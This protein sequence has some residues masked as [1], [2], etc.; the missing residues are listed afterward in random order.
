MNTGL[1][2]KLTVQI[3]K[4]DTPIGGS[5]RRILLIGGI[6]ATGTATT[7]TILKDVATSSTIKAELGVSSPIYQTLKKIND[8][9]SKGLTVDVLPT[10]TGT[11]T[12]DATITIGQDALED[13]V[14]KVSIGGYSTQI[15]VTK[16]DTKVVVATALETA[17]T[18]AE[19]F[20]VARVGD[21]LTLT[22]ISSTSDFNGV[23][24]FITDDS[25]TK[26][27]STV[28]SGGASVALTSLPTF[29]ERYTS[30][31]LEF[32]L[33]NDL[34][35]KYLELN[36]N[37][38]NI[39]L[40]GVV[41]E[42]QNINVIGAKTYGATQNYKTLVSFV[43]LDELKFNLIPMVATG[44]I[45][46]IREL[47]L[48]D[49]APIVDYVISP[50]EGIGGMNKASLPYFNTPLGFGKP[51]GFCEQADYNALSDAGVSTF[52]FNGSSVLGEVITT[53]KTDKVGL[54]DVSWKFLNYVDTMS[55]I[56]EYFF[57]SLRA[58]FGQTRMTDGDLVKGIAITNI[59]SFKANLVKL[60]NDL[61]DKGN[62]HQVGLTRA[63]L[64]SFFAN[65]CIVTQDL[66]KGTYNF[67]A[68]TP[69]VTQVRAIN[70]V[71]IETLDISLS[72]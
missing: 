64:G 27:V 18:G 14:L 66:A 45:V 49:N 53:Y 59:G 40:D 48:T 44:E 10:T 72:I 3:G 38:E 63:G 70:G 36:F 57:N 8:I 42:T 37:N 28:F 29:E 67:I 9:S 21:V 51:L 56:R 5:T 65:N 7:D 39:I 15:N 1:N 22:T 41:F 35:R 6:G 50:L 4:A 69:I 43:N 61:A 34:V 13:G 62:L 52:V 30:I 23:L 16:A 26:T 31:V 58:K 32:G 71:V 33:G 19:W 47:R 46:A 55:V 2:P 24:P 12:A 68:K 25:G 20:T 17:L 11:A 60:Y 54:A